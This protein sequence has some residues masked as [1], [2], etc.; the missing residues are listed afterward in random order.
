[1]T[2]NWTNGV[3]DQITNHA[4]TLNQA[5]HLTGGACSVFVTCSSLVP[6]GR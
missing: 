6:A 2:P 5:L 4:A 1:M 3:V